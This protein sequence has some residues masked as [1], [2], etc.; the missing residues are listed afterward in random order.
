[1]E[2]VIKWAIVNYV[3]SGEKRVP[4]LL[5]LFPNPRLPVVLHDVCVSEFFSFQNLLVVLTNTLNN[6]PKTGQTHS[7]LCNKKTPAFLQVV[8]QY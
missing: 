7:N 4:S 3:L 8:F 5:L 2:K 1:M 6:T